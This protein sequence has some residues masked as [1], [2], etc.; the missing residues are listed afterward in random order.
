MSIIFPQHR[1]FLRMFHALGY[2]KISIKSERDL[3]DYWARYEESMAEFSRLG[4]WRRRLDKLLFALVVLQM[5]LLAFA[6][7]NE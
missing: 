6:A 2:G 3:D 5:L 7:W 4:P 1:W